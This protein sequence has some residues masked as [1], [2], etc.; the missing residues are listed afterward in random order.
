[1]SAALIGQCCRSGEEMMIVKARWARCVAGLAALAVVAA[2]CGGSTDNDEAADEVVTEA[3]V[4]ATDAPAATV[5]PPTA[6]PT[7]VAALPTDAVELLQ[8]ALRNSAQ[9]P[10]RGEMRMSLGEMA[11]VSVQFETDASQNLSLALSFE[12]AMEDGGAGFGTEIRLIGEDAY[13]RIVVPEELAEL[14]AATMQ[15]GWFTLDAA[16][17]PEAGL[18]ALGVVCPSALPGAAPQRGSCLPPN[19]HT[20]LIEQI[21]SA[22]IIGQASID[23]VQTQHIRAL[24]DLAAIEEHF[25]DPDASGP[26]PLPPDLFSSELAFDIWIDADGLLRRVSADVASLMDQFLG[27]LASTDADTH[28]DDDELAAVLDISHVIDFHDY[29]ADITIEA[30]PPD[31]IL[32]D[33]GDLMGSDMMGAGLGAG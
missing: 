20:F 10:V 13:V 28:G 8:N 31:Q 29:D 25:A 12:E 5:P 22:E 23:G 32:G 7:T 18:A 19:D 6:A 24:V 27:G 11:S 26:I 17:T 21:T 1:M 33:F 9:R 2:A 4:A 15:D 14:L 3:S 16:S 30:P